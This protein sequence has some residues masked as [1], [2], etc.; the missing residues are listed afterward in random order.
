NQ[1]SYDFDVSDVI[2]ATQ[3]RDHYMN[4]FDIISQRVND[5]LNVRKE[6]DENDLFNILTNN[7]APQTTTKHEID[8]TD[9]DRFT[10]QHRNPKD[11]DKLIEE[12][13]KLEAS[14]ENFSKL[15]DNKD[16]LNF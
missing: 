1:N 12:R 9:L 7:Q 14:V 15:I 10:E 6:N 5:E 11:A 3:K 13:N 2:E 4:K 8:Y 16:T